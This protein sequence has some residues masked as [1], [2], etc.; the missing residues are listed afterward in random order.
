MPKVT[1][2]EQLRAA[3]EKRAA[4]VGA[5]DAIMERAA[6]AQ[7]TLDESEQEEFDNLQADNDELDKHIR[8]LKFM[9]SQERASAKAVTKEAGGSSSAASRTRGGSVEVRQGTPNLKPGV[10]F[11]QLA[12]CR[13]IAGLEHESALEVA[14]RLYPGHEA[15]T[16]ALTKAAVPAG[17]TTGAT[18]AGPLVGDSTS[19]FA[20]FVEFLRPMT[21]LGK[22]GANGV[23]SLRTVPFRTPLIGQSSGGSGYWVG[24]GKAKPLTKF[25]FTR[26]TLDPLKVANIAVVTRELLRDSSPS[27]DLILRDSLA[28][29]LRERM[30]IDFIDPAKAASSGVSPASV[31]NGASNAASSGVDAAG[32]RTDIQTLFN[33]FIDAN[34]TPTSGVWVMPAKTALTLSLMQNPLGQAEF[35]GVGMNGGSLFGLPVITS[36]YVPADSSGAIVALINASDI[37][38]ADDGGIEV[39]MSMEASLEMSN[40]PTGASDTPTAATLVSLWQT[41]SVGFLAERTINWKRRRDSAVAYLTGVNWATA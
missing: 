7:R 26:S 32:V 18:W 11:A 41:N 17:T 4:N 23:P 40:T 27:A 10:G 20:D 37:Y 12:R 33:L 24:E 6:E 38:Q 15:L 36:E 28:A 14:K 3:E 25:D 29:A 39:S 13:A 16:H 21:I 22:F 30:D 5:M 19:L 9:D 8:R 31:T 34:N 1:Y 35:P 2:A